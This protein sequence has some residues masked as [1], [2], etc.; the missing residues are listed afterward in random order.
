M[1]DKL[2]GFVG[3]EFI[4]DAI[5]D[6][7]K[8]N[9]SGYLIIRGDP[10]IGKSSL[11][12][13]L[14]SDHGYIHHFNIALQNI[15]S[16]KAFL[17]NICLQ[18]IARYNLPHN[19]LPQ[20][21]TENSSFLSQCLNEAADVRANHPVVIAIDALDEADHTG[22]PAEVNALYL[23]PSLPDGVYIIV[24]V[25]RIIDLHLHVSNR[26]T[27]D[28]E[29]NSDSNLQDIRVYI[30]KYARREQMLDRLSTWAMTKERFTETLLK[31]SQGNFMYLY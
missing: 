29:A 19:V 17:E 6:F 18:L 1:A 28:L 11:L 16:V 14:I 8:N 23:P 13:K 2:K 7:I 3:R 26:Q 22:L 25:R 21:A 10:G 27:L 24:T 12:A 20:N 5:N 4:F 31:K 30:E 9:Q 15:R